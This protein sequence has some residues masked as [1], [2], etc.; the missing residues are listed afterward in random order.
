MFRVIVAESKVFK[1]ILVKRLFRSP[2]IESG[3][4]WHRSLMAVSWQQVKHLCVH[5]CFYQC[6]WDRTSRTWY[7][8]V[9]KL[10]IRP[11]NCRSLLTKIDDSQ[12]KSIKSTMVC[13]HFGPRSM[14]LIWHVCEDR[15]FWLGGRPLLFSSSSSVYTHTLLLDQCCGAGR[16]PLPTRTTDLVKFFSIRFMWC[17]KVKARS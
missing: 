6:R 4:P 9:H 12:L 11:L 10:A 8:C 14:T 3:V 5:T 16:V 2:R 1:Q 17:L 15:P 7:F 13:A